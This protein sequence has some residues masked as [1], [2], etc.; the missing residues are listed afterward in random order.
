MQNLYKKAEENLLITGVVMLVVGLVMG[1]IFC[2]TEMGQRMYPAPIL[3]MI[4]GFGLF[5][6]GIV[7]EVKKARQ[8]ERE[9]NE[10][11]GRKSRY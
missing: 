1:I 2:T 3:I 9:W 10:R 7:Q 8:R 6:T 4:I 5:I 11:Y